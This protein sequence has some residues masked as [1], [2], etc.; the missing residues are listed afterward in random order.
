MCTFFGV[1]DFFGVYGPERIRPYWLYVKM[2]KGKDT[3][4]IIFF[5]DYDKEYEIDSL[6]QPYDFMSIMH[7]SLQTAK[8]ETMMRVRPEHADTIDSREIGQ[9]MGLSEGDKTQANL[10]YRCPG[11]GSYI[12]MY[13]PHRCSTQCDLCAAQRVRPKLG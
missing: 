7:Y 1:Y 12:Y 2:N 3:N 6:G 8:G 13:S 4:R 5:S 9:R 10:L 11:G